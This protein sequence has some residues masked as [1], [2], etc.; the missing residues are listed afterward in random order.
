[1]K[2]SENKQVYVNVVEPLVNGKT[3]LTE[4]LFLDAATKKL[5]KK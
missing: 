3:G 2:A 5:L 4:D 1:M